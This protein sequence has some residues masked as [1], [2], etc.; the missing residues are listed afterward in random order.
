MILCRK[1]NGFYRG[2]CMGNQMVASEIREILQ[3]FD[4]EASGDNVIC[5]CIKRFHLRSQP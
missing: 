1:Q 2:I 3:P 4:S 5:F